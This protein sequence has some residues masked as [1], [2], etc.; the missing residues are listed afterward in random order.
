MSGLIEG[1]DLLVKGIGESSKFLFEYA[2]EVNGWDM[3]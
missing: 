3:S 1:E 2:C